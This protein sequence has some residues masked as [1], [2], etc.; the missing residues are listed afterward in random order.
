VLTVRR[1][2]WADQT[3]DP[4]KRFNELLEESV[5]VLE[6][7]VRITNMLEDEQIITIEDLL[8]CTP[9][10]LL[11]IKNFG[12]KTLLSIDVALSH[13][14]IAMPSRAPE[15]LA[16]YAAQSPATEAPKLS[17]SA[18]L[19]RCIQ[20]LHLVLEN[21]LALH[22]ADSEIAANIAWVLNRAEDRAIQS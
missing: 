18:T 19:I 8:N 11:Q 22:G 5:S 16:G 17:A 21:A 7:S 20:D 2:L 12:V 1:R 14:G 3:K 4:V 9:S 13:L 15:K 10:R 6:L